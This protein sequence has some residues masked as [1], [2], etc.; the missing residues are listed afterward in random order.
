M[1]NPLVLA[2]MERGLK[3]W[4]AAANIG[5]APSYLSTIERGIYVPPPE[6]QSK[7]AKFY[8]KPIRELFP[9]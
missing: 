6:T 8:G 4:Q 9:A 7:I 5:I 2:R 3:A 1:I